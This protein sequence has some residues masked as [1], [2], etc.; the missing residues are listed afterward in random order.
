ME[1]KLAKSPITKGKLQTIKVEAPPKDPHLDY[2]ESKGYAVRP[3][4]GVLIKKHRNKGGHK[5]NT[6]CFSGVAATA[7]GK[8]AMYGGSSSTVFNDLRTLDSLTME[9][10]IILNDKV[11]HNLQGRYGHVV[12]AYDRFLVA[13]GGTGAYIQKIK[14][15]STKN[16]VAVFDLEQD[17]YTKFEADQSAYE[18]TKIP[19]TQED[20]LQTPSGKFLLRLFSTS[21]QEYDHWAGVRALSSI[22]APKARCFASGGTI[23]SGLFIHGGY[24]KV[25]SFRDGVF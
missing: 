18:A 1:V 4:V 2:L 16:D 9:W 11:R 14:V 8:F 20:L 3:M 15:R 19:K 12:G 24:G 25:D 22:M 6:R 7:H 13:F 10:R 5:P 17:D 23:G 21:H